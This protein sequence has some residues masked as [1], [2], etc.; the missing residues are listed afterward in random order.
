MCTTPDTAW[1]RGE[2]GVAVNAAGRLILSSGYAYQENGITQV[3]YNDVWRSNFSVESSTQLAARCGGVT[4]PSAGVGL[5]VW[6][7][8][9]VVPA[10]T[11]T[12]S[13][14]TLRAPWSPRFRPG[15]LLMNKPLV[16]TTVEGK[17]A[18]TGPD[19]LLLYEGMGIVY[20]TLALNEN[21][22]YA[23]VDNGAT[24]NLISGVSRRGAMG[25]VDSAYPDSS[26]AGSILSANCEDPNT[27]DVYSLGGTR[28][29]NTVLGFFGTTDVWYSS[30]ALTW[31]R[32]TGRSFDPPRTGAACD[33][34]HTGNLIMVGGQS[35]YPGGPANTYL[36]DVYTSNNKGV[37]WVRTLSK[38]LF[39]ARSRH[40]MQ[41]SRS[42]HY[43]VD[44]IFVAGGL[45]YTTGGMTD[46][47]NDVSDLTTPLALIFCPL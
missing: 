30:N 31:T 37:T 5:R 45:T 3:R 13:S 44:L 28:Y 10:N 11:M 14:L 8:R 6:P 18:S 20:N 35:S 24:W 32:R 1:I 19:W 7:G 15:L 21:D 34:G 16:Y 4:L 22:V 33:V 47:L 29:N 26:F 12:F 43:D 17:K 42:D 25:S 2:Q 40:T 36:N 39:P 38:A 23:S 46:S 41:I 9:P 27:D